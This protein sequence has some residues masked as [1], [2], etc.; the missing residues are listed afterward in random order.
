MIETLP[1]PLGLLTLTARGGAITAILFEG[2]AVRDDAPPTLADR[3]ELD[4][5]RA[6]L[7]AYFA[8][9][10]T[11]FDLT[12]APEGTAFQQTVWKAL[13]DIPYG[14]T[15]GYGELARTIGRPTAARA[16]GAANGQNRI[17]IVIPCHRVIG[18]SG[19]LTGYAAGVDRKAWLLDHEAATSAHPAPAHPATAS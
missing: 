18:A 5:A 8:G 11:S 2:Q 7:D 17:G 9:E 13:R 15:R 14:V 10:R 3:R 12:L 19:A 16:V 1:S 6:Q 4:R